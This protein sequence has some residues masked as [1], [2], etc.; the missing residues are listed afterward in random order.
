MPGRNSEFENAPCSCTFVDIYVGAK[1]SIARLQGSAWCPVCNG[2]QHRS[3][4]FLPLAAAI[5]TG[6]DTEPLSK[7]RGGESWWGAGAGAGRSGATPL[8]IYSQVNVGG[9]S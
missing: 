6:L 2:T 3:R 4:T 9:K 5:P 1:I 8:C 7:P